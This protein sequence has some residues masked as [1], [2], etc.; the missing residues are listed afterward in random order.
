MPTYDAYM[1]KQDDTAVA[2]KKDIQ[3]LMDMIATVLEEAHQTKTDLR[4]EI[5]DFRIMLTNKIEN[6]QHYLSLAAGTSGG[7][8]SSS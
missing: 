2:T 5:K 3:R 6:V 8:V 7:V 4:V 1:T